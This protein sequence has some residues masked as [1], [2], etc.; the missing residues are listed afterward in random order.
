MVKKID[1][2]KQPF[3]LQELLSLLNQHTEI[4]LTEGS[5]PQARLVA[6]PTKPNKLRVPGLHPQAFRLSEDFDAPL[7]DKF[8]LGNI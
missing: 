4:I 8:W 3:N 2:K 1:I 6:L 7:P 5:I